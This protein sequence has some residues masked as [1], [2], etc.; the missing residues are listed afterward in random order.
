VVDLAGTVADG[1]V[2]GV[3]GPIGDLPGGASS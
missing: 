3:A 2:A 1:R